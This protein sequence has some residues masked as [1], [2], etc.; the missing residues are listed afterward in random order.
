LRALLARFDLTY[1]RGGN[2][3][4]LRRALRQSGADRILADL[5]AQDAIVYAGYSAAPCVH[6]PTLRGLESAEDDPE[7]VP[8][9][10]DETVIWDGLGLLPFALAPHYGRELGAA[11]A[12]PM[13]DYYIEHHIPFVA[14]RDGQALVLDGNRQV[15]VG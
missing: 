13:V 11:G 2:V 7:T 1:V 14:L 8:E 9:G 4:I 10:Y 15:V 3:F 6:G 12:T 5:L